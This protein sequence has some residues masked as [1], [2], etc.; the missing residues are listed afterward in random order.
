M[1]STI[2]I[3]TI[4]TADD[5]AIYEIIRNIMLEYGA[6]PEGTILGDPVIQALSESYQNEGSVYYLAEVNGEIVG[7]GGINKLP[8]T[9]EKICELQRMFLLKKAR[10]KG[11]GKTLIDKCLETA[12]QFH[13]TGCYLETLPNMTEAQH[14][15][16]KSGFHYLEKPMGNTG[17]NTC[18]V[19]M[20]KD[21]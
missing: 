3:R 17:H 5:P 19:W 4:G 10:G 6:T 20:Y 11:I 7:G 2:N 18:N 21:L 15:Y 1:D 14:L 16:Q 8:G 13:Y 9:E 12:T